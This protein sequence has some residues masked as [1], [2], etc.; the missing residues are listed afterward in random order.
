MSFAPYTRAYFHFYK[1]SY[2]LPYIPKLFLPHFTTIIIHGEF[3]EKLLQWNKK[4]SII[5]VTIKKGEENGKIQTNGSGKRTGNVLN[6]QPE[7]TVNTR[8]F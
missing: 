7:R 4:Q 2:T 5:R 8:H 1:K 3:V 6:G